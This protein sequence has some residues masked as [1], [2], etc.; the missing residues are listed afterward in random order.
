MKV[1]EAVSDYVLIMKNGKIIEQGKSDDVF[2][3]PKQSYTVQLL[4]S[5]V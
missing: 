3:N 5:V 2:N 4:S 1:I